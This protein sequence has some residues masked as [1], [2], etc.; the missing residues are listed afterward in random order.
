MDLIFSIFENDPKE[1]C[2]S[3]ESIGCLKKGVDRVSIEKIARVFL[4]EFQTGTKAVNG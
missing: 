4:N 2:N 3:L 1:A